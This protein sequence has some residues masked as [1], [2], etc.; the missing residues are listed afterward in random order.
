MHRYK[1]LLKD[2]TVAYVE[3]KWFDLSAIFNQLV[4]H[5]PFIQIGKAVF[6]KDA[7]E[8]IQKN[9]IEEKENRHE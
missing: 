3:S 2:G 6:A 9:D 1:F 8:M 7:I 5:Q 4:D